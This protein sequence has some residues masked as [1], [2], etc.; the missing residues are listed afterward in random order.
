MRASVLL[1]G[2]LMLASRAVGVAHRAPLLRTGNAPLLAAAQMSTHALSCQPKAT[3]TMS[4]FTAAFATKPNVDREKKAI[5]DV[6]TSFDF[7]CAL[8]VPSALLLNVRQS[9]LTCARRVTTSSRCGRWSLVCVAFFCLCCWSR[10]RALGA[11]ASGA[12]EPGARRSRGFFL[13]WLL[14]VL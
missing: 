7:R 11:D 3:A 2:S 10:Q 5:A 14:C 4:R 1:R 6:T 12:Q 8:R 9:V 13:C